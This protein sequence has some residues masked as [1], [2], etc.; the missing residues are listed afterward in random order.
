MP[1]SR[2]GTRSLQCRAIAEALFLSDG[3][4]KTHLVRIYRKRSGTLRAGSRSTTASARTATS[5][6]TTRATAP[7]AST[8]RRR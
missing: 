6:G 5:S 4:V 7:R 1:G 2:A 8:S 3:T